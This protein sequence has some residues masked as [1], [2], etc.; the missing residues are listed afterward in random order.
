MSKDYFSAQADRYV[1]FRPHYPGALF[2]ALCRD[3]PAD[4]LVWDCATGN[5]QA[6]TMLGRKVSRVVG[7][8]QSAA[9]L[10]NALPHEHV[11]YVQAYAEA[12]PLGDGS[13][14]LITV[15]Q[16]LHWFDFGRFYAEAARVLK[17]GAMI[18]AWTY[19]FLSVIPQ[20]GDDI[21][22]VLRGF[23][24][25]VVGPYW[26]AEHRWVN[27][28]YRTI[29]FPFAAIDIG[30]FT[31]DVAWDL[32]SV[33]GYVSSWSA[34]QGYEAATGNDPMPLLVERLAEP[35]GAPANTRRLRWPLNIR[36]G[37]APA[38]TR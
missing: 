35:W 24:H 34:T 11:H 5:G 31:I 32:A 37:R 26:P 10:R 1:A 15:A 36:A 13:V 23:Y 2:A 18:V 38:M 6:A 16:A 21:E 7:S 4:A 33:A 17:P 12:M 3:L 30:E 29:P 19:S 25:D 22:R 20:L 9:Q 27:E 28:G 14:D 8:D